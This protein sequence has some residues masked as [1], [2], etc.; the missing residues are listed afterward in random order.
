MNT[1]INTGQY[2]S[3]F[4][5]PE[6][7]YALAH[8]VGPLPFAAKQA[9]QDH[10]L[11]PWAALGGDA[12]PS[13]LR[14][15]DAFCDSV[16]KLLN[17]AS[18][19][20]CPQP[21]LA[22]GFS[23]YLSAIAK[24]PRNK[25]KRRILMHEDAFASMGF[26]VKG[27]AETYQL[28]LH[29]VTTNPNNHD[30][31]EAELAGNDVL[32]CLFT[33]VHSNTSIKSDVEPLIT[34]AKKYHAYALVDVAQSV[35]VV[36]I[37]AQRW[38]AD[39]IFGSSVKWLCGG[40]GAGFMTLTC[41]QID[42]L[43]PDPIGWFSHQNPFEFDINHYAPATTAK[44]FWGGTPSVASYVTATA[45]IDTILNIGVEK[46]AQHNMDL[47][48]Y[49]LSK[50]PLEVSI[51][52]SANELQQQGGSICIGCDDMDN[53]A[54]KLANAGVRFDRRGDIF[55][56]SLHIMNDKHDADIIARCFA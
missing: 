22:S 1:N 52:P 46:I 5:L 48:C 10:Y 2:K 25:N 4:C 18:D 49:L 42:E 26:V 43:H 28:E 36:P 44:R 3:Q 27:L 41:D 13:W 11:S 35:G 24:L 23:A 34:L 38:K 40:P 14:S 31:W 30:A 6:G 47:K 20:V 8:S 9:L 50:L 37:D 55:R 53:T 7:V 54:L 17:C 12:W 16:A 51:K 33:H 15:I 39:A 19:E 56:L 21:N 32:A 45:A 29:L